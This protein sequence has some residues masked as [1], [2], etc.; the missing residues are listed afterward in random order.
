MCRYAITLRALLRGVN[1]IEKE[2]ATKGGLLGKHLELIE[3]TAPESYLPEGETMPEY[4]ETPLLS[5]LACSLVLDQPVE[6]ACGFIICVRCCCKWIRYNATSSVACP[7]CYNHQLDS[8]AI[9]PPPPLVLT[10]LSDL[11]LHCRKKCG[12]LVQ[13]SSYRRHIQCN[14]E[15]F[16]QPVMDSPSKIT[17]KDVLSKP[18]S[19]PATPTEMKVTEHLVRRLLDKSPEEQMIRVSR[20]VI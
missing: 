10:L 5:Q 15:N 18:V 9:R 1:R 2:E 19:I 7:C 8:S 11:L 12:K 14:C 3:S 16:Y 20:L 17:L 13:A 4:K 6:L